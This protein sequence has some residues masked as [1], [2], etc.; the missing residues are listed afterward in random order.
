V[1]CLW[2]NQVALLKPDNFPA[3]NNAWAVWIDKYAENRVGYID[4][5][6]I[7]WVIIEDTGRLFG[8]FRWEIFTDRV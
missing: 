5:G 6:Y 2:I 8:S 4:L 1:F 7:D 3:I